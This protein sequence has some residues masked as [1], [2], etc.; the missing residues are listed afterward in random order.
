MASASPTRAVDFVS[1]Q[2]RGEGE[3]A[4]ADELAEK[5]RQLAEIER[6]LARDIER[7]AEGSAIAA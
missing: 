2:S 6:A 4:F 1:Y 7:D 3:F 5:R